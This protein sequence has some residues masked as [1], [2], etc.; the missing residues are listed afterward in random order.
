[1]RDKYSHTGVFIHRCKYCSSKYLGLA[2][3]AYDDNLAYWVKASY[4]ELWPFLK[5]F[6][7]I[8]GNENI[9]YKAKKL[10]ESK[11]THIYGA[12]DGKYYFKCEKAVVLS[13]LSP[14]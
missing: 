4:I 7:K 8:K 9:F 14:W 5:P 12:Q 3:Q 6:F 13:G 11:S 2:V 1:M 10:I